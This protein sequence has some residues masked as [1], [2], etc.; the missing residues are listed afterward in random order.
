MT[1]WREDIRL[2]RIGS[3]GANSHESGH[4][5]VLLKLMF[6]LFHEKD[7]VQECYLRIWKAK[8]QQPIVSAKA[9]L[10]RVARNVV[11]DGLRRS[12]ISPIAPVGDLAA[13]AVIDENNAL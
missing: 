11:L 1:V 12:Y 9:F 3:A 10:F 5:V 7:V 13:L 6:L 4:P 2:K 8:A